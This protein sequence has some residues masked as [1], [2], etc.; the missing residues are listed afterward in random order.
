MS[1]NVEKI[2]L[3]F[4]DLEIISTSSE[5]EDWVKLRLREV[6]PHAA[7]L[8]TF[9]RLYGVGSVPTHRVGVDFPLNL[10]EEMK[11]KF[12]AIDDPM[13]CRWFV[14]G[15]LTFKEIPAQP[16]EVGDDRW[17]KTL[18]KYGITSMLVCGLLDH[19][20]KRF[21]LFQICNLRDEGKSSLLQLVSQLVERMAVVGWKM[22]DSRSVTPSRRLF[23]HPTVALTS[24]E[25]RI[26][27]FLSLGLSNKEIARRRG[28]S[29][30]TIK[31]QVSRTGAKLGATR[32]AEIVA[33]G[34]SMLSSLPSQG[35]INYDD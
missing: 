11:D 16:K 32:R 21:A 15:K 35:L 28:V 8:G 24:T 7:F 19:H 13:V 30:S 1:T 2:D 27:E 33:V 20:A 14:S 22:F 9:G 3:L 31:T 10:A 29:S 34:M 6:L 5:F 26:I 18:R 12:G 25:I 17:E 23:G 4:A